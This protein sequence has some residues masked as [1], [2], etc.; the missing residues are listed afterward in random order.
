[1]NGA[2]SPSSG[3]ASTTGLDPN[4]AA[5]LAYLAGPLSGLLVLMAESSNTT[6]RFHAWQSIIAIG[7]MW[8]ASLVLYALAFASIL[9]GSRLLLTLLWLAVLV[10][11]SSIVVTVLSVIKAWSGQPWKLPLA[12]DYAERKALRVS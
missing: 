6:V 9:V 12:G 8:T 4:I 11:V 3:G 5:A 10:A 1:V 7:A 2:P